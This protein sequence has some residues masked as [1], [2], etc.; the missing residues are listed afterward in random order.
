MREE[1]VMVNDDEI[2]IDLLELLRVLLNKLWMIILFTVV[3]AILALGVTKFLITPQYTATSMIYILSKTTSVSSA[4]DLQLSKQLTVDFEILAKSRPVIENVIDELDLDYTYEEMLDL[5]EVE[6]PQDSSILKMIVT[7]PEP[8]L[9]KEIA[10]EMA[11]AT[12]DRVAEVMVTDK[13]SKV[14]SAVTPEKPSS[15]STLKNT[16]LG[17]LGLGFL[18]ALIIAIKHLLDDT[19]KTEDDV[20]KYL[21]LSTLAAIPLEKKKGAR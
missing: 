9:S 1:N 18:V 10:S 6:N 15:P 3:G 8:E 21:G 17:G 5:V 11:D 20:K 4:V 16:L 7:T 13:P 14:E 2:E 19:I 12:A